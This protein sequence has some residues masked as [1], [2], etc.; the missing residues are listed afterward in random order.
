MSK[1][2]VIYKIDNLAG[3]L[4]QKSDSWV[5]AQRGIKEN[6][7][8]VVQNCFFDD[9]VGIKSRDGY[10]SSRDIDYSAV[11]TQFWFA[12][13][14]YLS[15]SSYLF[16]RYENSSDDKIYDVLINGS[17][18][19]TAIQNFT[20]GALS[21]DHHIDVAVYKDVLFIFDRE[22]GNK[23]WDGTNLRN[24]GITAPAAA[25]TVATGAAGALDDTYVY[26]Y[27]YYN[28]TTDTESALSP[29]S[30]S[31]SPSSEKVELT[32]IAASSDA[33]VDYKR[34]YRQQSGSDAILRLDPSA[35]SGYGE[36]TNATTTYSDN[37]TGLTTEQ[38]CENNDVLA[39][40][41]IGEIHHHQ[42]FAAGRASYREFL[43]ESRFYKPE[44]FPDTYYTQIA[45]GD[46]IVAIKELGIDLIVYTNTRM[47]RYRYIG[48][49]EA[50]YVIEEIGNVGCM[51]RH[52]LVSGILFNNQSCHIFFGVSERTTGVFVFDGTNLLHISEAVDPLFTF[53]K[54]RAEDELWHEYDT[55]EYEFSGAYSKNKYY[56]AMK[57]YDGTNTPYLTYMF[58]ISDL[59]QGVGGVKI[60][61]MLWDG[62]VTTYSTLMG[63]MYVLTGK[64]PYEAPVDPGLGVCSNERFMCI[65]P[66]FDSDGG[67]AIPLVY[68]TG[69]F[70]DRNVYATLRSVTFNADTAGLTLTVKIYT[71]YSLAATLTCST[72]SMDR[73][74]LNVPNTCYGRLFSVRFEISA[75]SRVTISPPLELKVSPWRRY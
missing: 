2:F 38:D 69:Y 64:S 42:M 4:N 63:G 33:Q 65:D 6:Q 9:K 74:E 15:G 71:D 70:G 36:I 58:D 25:C 46:Q 29:V 1:E 12:K 62:G 5:G 41:S 40:C 49:T 17:G 53:E 26:Y 75:T 11:L 51:S 39:N 30:A 57:T 55:Q 19:A 34:L 3:G 66:L 60:S 44:A 21:V 45:Q 8:I 67:S 7:G 20:A 73:V 27:S 72:S 37:N 52:T 54:P 31:V 56:V 14:V 23:K 35:N 47:Y 61:Q 68:Q 48:L 16:L 59:A 13:P 24:M 10:S 32:V 43:Y 50:D 28:S 22:N 18:T